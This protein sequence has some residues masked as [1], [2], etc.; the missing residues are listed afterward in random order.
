MLPELDAF[1]QDM[2]LAGRSPHSCARWPGTC[3]RFQGEPTAATLRAHLA[4]FADRSPATRARKQASF[5]SYFRWAI[6]N[7]VLDANPLDKMERV[8]VEPPF[9]A[10]SPAR[11]SRRSWRT[12]IRPATGCCTG[13][14]SSWVCESGRR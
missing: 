1:L 7:D 12:W 3:A 6:K 4:Q 8:R 14:S 5:G 9:P 11:S 10:P 2:T 13:S